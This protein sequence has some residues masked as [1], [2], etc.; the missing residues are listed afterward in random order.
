MIINLPT[1]PISSTSL[2]QTFLR[3]LPTRWRQKPA[4]I[5]VELNYVTVILC[6]WTPGNRL[7]VVLRRALGLPVGGAKQMTL[8]RLQCLIQFGTGVV[9]H[10]STFCAPYKYFVSYFALISS[11]LLVTVLATVA[12]SRLPAVFVNE[13]YR[14]VMALTLSIQVQFRVFPAAPP[15]PPTHEN[16]SSRDFVKHHFLVTVTG[17]I[18]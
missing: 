10:Q 9:D 18:G 12:C 6:I 14:T 7:M 15:H 11:L 2:Q 3:A 16:A 8:L 13:S 1:E 5:D 17:H 4:G